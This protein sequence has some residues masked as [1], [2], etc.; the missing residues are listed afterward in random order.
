E[1]LIAHLDWAAFARGAV[2]PALP[3]GGALTLAVGIIGATV[4]PHAIYL[5]SALTQNRMPTAGLAQ[6]RRLLGFSNREVVLA[7]SFAGVVNMAMVGMA[8]AVFHAGHA[9]VAEI[10]TAY[11]LLVP[12][13]GGGAGIAFMAALLASG[14]SSSVVGTMAGQSIMQDFLRWRTPL[15][16]R[17]AI[18]MLPAF[19]VVALGWN[20][21]QSLMISQVVL[22]LALPVPMLALLWFTGRRAVM[23]AFVNS[24]LTQAVAVAAALVVMALNAVLLAQLAGVAIPGLG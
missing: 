15:W 2:V 7:L 16:L 3:D 5:H 23:G 9:D 21:T 8:A 12:L 18:T 20:A 22:S 11:H 1:V 10:E 6:R 13:L 24:R 4:M 17:R 14:F 19:A